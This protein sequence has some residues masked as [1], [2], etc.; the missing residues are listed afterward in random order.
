MDIDIKSIAEKLLEGLSD[1]IDHFQSMGEGVKL[2]YGR[3]RD[4]AAELDKKREREEVKHSEPVP[5]ERSE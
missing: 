2:L 1:E 5:S 3:I 4:A